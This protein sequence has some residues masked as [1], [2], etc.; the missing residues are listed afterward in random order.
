ME[1]SENKA[2]KQSKI[3]FRF[4]S[5]LMKI[6]DLFNPPIRK[7][8]K[9]GIKEGDFVLDYGCGPGSYS[10]AAAKTVG[11]N[12]KVYSADIN[13][14]AIKKVKMKAKNNNLDN[15]KTIETDCKTELDNASIDVVI[16]FDVLHAIENN[17]TLLEEFHR[18]L[19]PEGIF[20]LDDHHFNE[21]EIKSAMKRNLAGKALFQL[22]EKKD[23]QYNFV[24]T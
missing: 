7:I 22:L 4:M 9:A 13:S 17:E 21:I 23:K 14:L 8:E 24:K 18:V 19:K 2:K 12:G 11:S 1:E 10:I 3:D 5:F 6:R 20:S 16:C 15:I